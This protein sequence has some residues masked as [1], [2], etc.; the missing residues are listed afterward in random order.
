MAGSNPADDWMLMDAITKGDRSAL[1]ALYD[2]HA[3]LLLSICCRILRDAS[4][5]EDVLINIFFEVWRRAD[6][7]DPGRGSP[8]TYLVTLARSRAIDHKRSR[9]SRPKISG[10]FTDSDSAAQ[11]PLSDSP[12]QSLEIREQREQIRKCLA[13]LEPAQREVLECAYFDGLSHSEIAA[14]LNRPLGTVKTYIRQ[15]LIRLRET[16]RTK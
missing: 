7:F 16:L 13:D 1:S 15:G 10:D 5:A 2:R 11:T 8:L 3:P 12:A 6:R 4:E 14:K 9:D